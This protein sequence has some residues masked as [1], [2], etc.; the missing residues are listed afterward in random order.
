MVLK[1]LFLF[2][3][4]HQYMPS[5]HAYDFCTFD[6]AFD[7]CFLIRIYQY[8]CIYLCIPLGINLNPLWGVSDSPGLAVQVL[9]LGLKWSP[10][11]KINLTSQ[12]RLT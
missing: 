4:F 11:P 1:D 9:K 8:T 3:C 2:N 6:T 12:S 5:L 10:P 7:A